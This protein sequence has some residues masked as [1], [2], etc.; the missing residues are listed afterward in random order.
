VYLGLTEG[1]GTKGTYVPAHAV[2]GK[3][4]PGHVEKTP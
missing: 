1:E 4:I 2:D 3:V